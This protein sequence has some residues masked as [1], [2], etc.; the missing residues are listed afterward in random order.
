M[1]LA[2]RP[3]PPEATDHQARWELDARNHNEVFG[4][5]LNAHRAAMG[6]PAVDDVR[7]HVLTDRPWPAAD[8]VPAPWPEPSD[9]DA[10]QTGAWIL[11]DDR[12]LPAGVT[13]FLDAGD[14]P[15]YVG[16]GSMRAPAD[17]AEVAIEAI[18]A[19][20]RRVVVGRGWADLS[21]MDDGADCCA[22]GEVNLHALSRGWPRWCSTVGPARRRWPRGPARRRWWS[23]RRWA[24][25]TGPG[26]WP[27]W[28]SGWP[29]EGPAPTV[30]SLSSAL[31]RALAPET[32]A[33]ARAVAAAMRTDG[34]A[35][36]A[37]WLLDTAGSA[38]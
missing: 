1:P 38:R 29:C 6:L 3:F 27:S 19:Q 9:L 20:G 30:E 18:R 10:G 11:P 2:G 37:S 16:F 21:L 4:A 24:S 32:A 5:A 26:G 25:R 34:A 8:P 36:A 31:E 23:S 17:V 7:R 13:A 15:V 35:V 28:A 33:R 14:P 12:P 22:V